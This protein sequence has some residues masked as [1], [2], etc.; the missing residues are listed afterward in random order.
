[1]FLYD[2]LLDCAVLTRYARNHHSGVG[3]SPQ[4]ALDVSKNTALARGLRKN[5]LAP[6]AAI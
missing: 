5:S 2:M 3:D 6:R 1:M 4:S